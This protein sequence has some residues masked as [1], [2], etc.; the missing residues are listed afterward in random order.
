MVP[1]NKPTLDIKEEEAVIKV[2]KSNW[3]AQGKEVQLFED[4]FCEYLGL[5][6][7][8]SVAV[9]SGTSALYVALVAL[10]CVEKS[11]VY[12]SYVCSAVR[13]AVSMTNSSS[14][15]I[16][17][18]I[19]SPNINLNDLNN[20]K[21]EFA[22]L[23]HMFGIPIDLNQ[24]KS[25]IIIEDCCQALG[26]TYNGLPVGL[27]GEVGVY[28]FYAT[29]IIT[30][31]GQGGMI[32]SKNKNLI[33]FIK[34]Y[35]EF[36]MKNDSLNRFNFQMTDIQ[37]S[38]GRIQLSKLKMFTDRRETIFK[39]YGEA[40]L[41]LVKSNL[42]SSISSSVYYRAVLKTDFPIEIMER[43]REN[44]IR[45]I[46]PITEEELLSPTSNAISFTKKTLSLPIYP[47]LSNEELQK[48]IKFLE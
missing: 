32:V 40:G 30:S 31:G 35:R 9:S 10:G 37:A 1:H 2:V 42:P 47:S 20:S 17:V 44:D 15:I 16:D 5:P 22:I 24:V 38:I 43:L 41:K 39:A 23:P 21:S 46:I 36:D 34:D 28:S 14:E 6:H 19:D 26:A 48:I 4:E 18:D 27:T 12:P 45:T 7:G 8:H 3:L 25:K 33:D 11:V 29:K 13:N